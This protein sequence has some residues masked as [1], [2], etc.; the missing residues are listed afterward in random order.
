MDDAQHHM[1]MRPKILQVRGKLDTWAAIHCPA[2]P[3]EVGG[4][5]FKTMQLI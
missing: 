2:V 5:S 3:R 4:P 1:Q